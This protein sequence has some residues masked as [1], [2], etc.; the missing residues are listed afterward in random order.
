MLSKTPVTDLTPLQG[1]KL[2]VLTLSFKADRDAKVLRSIK[3]LQRIN[4]QAAPE[5]WK[6]WAA[7]SSKKQ[8]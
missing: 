7:K 1:M 2:T 6:A 8:S 3:T 5:F 4:N